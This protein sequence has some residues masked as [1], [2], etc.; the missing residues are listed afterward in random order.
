MTRL[1]F[2]KLW[3][4]SETARAARNIVFHQ[5]RTLLVGRNHT[6]KSTVV[7]HLFRTLG[8]QTRG[9]S[10]RWDSLTISVLEFELDGRSYTAYRK[11]NVYALRENESSQV[12]VTTSYSEWAD[13]MAG[14]FDFRLM[15][16]THQETLAQATPPFLFLPYYMDQDGS[17]LNQWNSFDKLTQFSSWKKPLVAYVTGQ[18]PNGYYL[19][20]FEESK[21]K[22]SM[23]Q[24]NQ[25]LGVVQ[26]ALTRVRKTLPR[27]TIRLDTGA[28]KQEITDLLRTSTLLKSEQEALRKKAFDCA[29]QRESLS[30][31]ISMA[32]EAL[33]ELEGDLKYLTESKTELD[34]TCPTCGTNHESG[35]PVRLALI[36]DAVTLR[37]VLSELEVEH[38]KCDEQLANVYGKINRVKRRMLDIEK[39]LQTKKG[40]LRLQDVVDSQSS[41]VIRTAF[42][43]DIDSLKRQLSAQEEIA[44]VAKFK[45]GQ[46]DLPERTKE[47]NCFYS[48]RMELFA[49]E[50]G[51]HD[52]REDVNKRPDAR[53]SASGSALPRSLLAYQF[54]VL[55]TAKEKGDA[56]HFPVII[57]SPN[58]QGQ[59]ANHLRQM[60]SFI[61]KRTPSDQQLILA[62]EDRPSDL[63]FDGGLVELT[64]A[65]GLLDAGQYD[66]ACEE[67][68]DMVVAVETGLDQRL[69]SSRIGS[70]E[71]GEHI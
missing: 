58:Q 42:S 22:A 65:F 54:A 60:L 5:N 52:L 46:F 69:A 51:V 40:M 63:T 23:N 9:T 36:D 57:D 25:E 18:R 50:L 11:A 24:L 2:K 4:V 3:L 16:P 6:G 43:K 10:D 17:W 1:R 47:I 34:I 28:F 53:I 59:D 55:H 62:V 21:A 66:L 33:R 35:F 48:E 15:L 56:K 37:K 8:C 30:S 45:V 44:A 39:I 32:R 12:R 49:S 7:K 29:S 20:K 67:L 68:R 31:Q 38:R 14:L 27:P 70:L 41:E 13:I 71:G 61:V 26:S 19:E 64:T